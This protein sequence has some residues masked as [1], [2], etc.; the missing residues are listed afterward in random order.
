MRFCLSLFMFLSVLCTIVSGVNTVPEQIHIALAGPSGMRIMWFTRDAAAISLCNFGSSLSLGTEVVGVQ[1]TYLENYGSHHVVHLEHLEQDSTYY[2][3]VG[4]NSTMSQIFSFRTSPSSSQSK[5]ISIAVYGDMGWL[6]S[7][8]RPMGVLGSITMS[9]NWS[10]TF[11]RQLLEKMN[12]NHE[13]DL[14][15]HVGDVGYADDAVFHSMKTFVQFEYEDAYN[16]YM[17]WMQNITSTIP[18][19]VS[20]GNHES[21]CHDPACVVN[22]KTLGKPVSNFTAYTNRW[23]MPSP[24]SGGLLNMWYR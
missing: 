15:F 7:V 16:G 2:Y 20:V 24:E 9:G 8:S 23:A 10:A 4:D 17:N 3:S 13:I 12:N 6:D 18:Y 14:V 11:S 22:P 1:K 19:H 5:A 21:E